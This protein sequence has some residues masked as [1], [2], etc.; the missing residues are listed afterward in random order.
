MGPYMLCRTPVSACSMEK[1]SAQT[2]VR[3]PSSHRFSVSPST[4]DRACSFSPLLFVVLISNESG[5]V[6]E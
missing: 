6:A 3:V 4:T 2:A 5:A 1:A